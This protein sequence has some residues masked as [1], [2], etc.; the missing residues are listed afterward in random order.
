PGVAE[1]ARSLVP[2]PPW[3]RRLRPRREWPPQGRSDPCPQSDG[4][5]PADLQPPLP[6][7]RPDAHRPGRGAHRRRARSPAIGREVAAPRV[8]PPRFRRPR[9]IAALTRP[10]APEVRLHPHRALLFRLPG[11]GGR[12]PETVGRERERSSPL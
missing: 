6:D 8:S 2:R 5:P 7:L 3:D 9:G 11:S 12:A 10:L 4:R 1:S